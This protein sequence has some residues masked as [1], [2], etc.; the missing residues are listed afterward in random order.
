MYST[1]QNGRASRQN[2]DKE[3]YPRERLIQYDEQPLELNDPLRGRTR[4]SPTNDGADRN[5]RD[6]DST[7]YF[8]EHGNPNYS[9]PSEA[10]ISRN[11]WKNWRDHE[12]SL[13]S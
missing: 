4:D 8:T 5:S 2:P 13:S 1:K 11:S 7:P 3:Y 10:R 6:S 9:F 12:F